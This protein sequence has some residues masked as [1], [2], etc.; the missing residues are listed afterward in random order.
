MLE[1]TL[2]G[3]KVQ[4]AKN[5]WFED[6]VGREEKKTRRSNTTKKLAR[7]SKLWVKIDQRISLSGAVGENGSII[8]TEPQKSIEL[9]RQWQKIFDKKTM[10]S[11]AGMQYLEENDDSPGYSTVSQPTQFDYIDKFSKRARPSAPGPDGIP[12]S[13]LSATGIRGVETLMQTDVAIR[14]GSP[15]I[16]N[17]NESGATFLSKGSEPTDAIEVIRAAMSTRPISTKNSDNKIMISVNVG[18]LE[19]E[20]AN[21]I[22]DAQRGFVADRNFLRN[23]LD[24]DSAARIF[25]CIS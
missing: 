9:G 15:P 6:A 13:G 7:L 12:Y 5:T 18:C 14:Q 2:F 22:R 4:E 8:R 17:F 20:Y 1:P 25:P 3:E 16:E 23:V 24:L 11:S 21:N 19:S 10:C